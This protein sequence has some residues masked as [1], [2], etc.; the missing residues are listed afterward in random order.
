MPLY[1][2]VPLMIFMQLKEVEHKLKCEVARSNQLQEQLSSRELFWAGQEKAL[3]DTLQQV[4]ERCQDLQ[5]QNT[6]LHEE[7]EKVLWLN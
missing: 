3:Q 2:T 1:I 4:Q 5:G 7:A 6:L